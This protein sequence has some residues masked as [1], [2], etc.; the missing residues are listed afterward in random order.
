MKIYQF[1]IMDKHYQA[2]GLTWDAA[3]ENFN[4]ENGFNFTMKYVQLYNILN[5]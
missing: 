3:F 2:K 4:K 1:K 5:E